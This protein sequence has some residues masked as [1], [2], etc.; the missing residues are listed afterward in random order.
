MTHE[1]DVLRAAALIK[2]RDEA[3]YQAKLNFGQCV[4]YLSEVSRKRL[5]AAHADICADEIVLIKAQLA[6]LGVSA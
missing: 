3:A 5:R 4:S 2:A 1:Q 6:A